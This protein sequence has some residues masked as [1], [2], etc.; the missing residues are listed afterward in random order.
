MVDFI[1]S[2]KGTEAEAHVFC[3]DCFW[4][5]DVLAERAVQI[6]E[7]HVKT[8]THIENELA[9]DEMQAVLERLT[10]ERGY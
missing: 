9:G 8:D 7:E 5:E 2:I 10:L 1:A 4:G 6:V 3:P